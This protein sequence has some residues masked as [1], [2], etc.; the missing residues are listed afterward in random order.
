MNADELFQS[1]LVKLGLTYTI[2]VEDLYLIQIGDV[3]ATVNLENVRRNY[4]RD[5]DADAI[6]RF[7]KQLEA[8]YFGHTPDWASVKPFVRYSL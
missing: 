5:K 4:E 1:E 8:D 3:T 2:T 7:T 6:A